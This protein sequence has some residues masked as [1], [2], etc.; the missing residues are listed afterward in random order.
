MMNLSDIAV[1]DNCDGD[2]AD[3]SASDWA[4]KYA[5]TALDNGMVAGNTNFRPDDLVSMIEGLK[6]IFQA[7]EIEREDNADWRAGY[8]NT[9]VEMG[10]ATPFTN[11][12]DAVTRGQMFIWAV[13]AIDAGEDVTVEDDLLCGILGTCDDDMDDNMDNG[14]DNGDNTP[15]TPVVGGALEFSLSPMTPSAATIPGGVNGLR[16]AAYDV[17]AG[18]SDVTINQVTL[19][20]RGLSDKDTIDAVALFGENGRISNSRTFNQ[21]ND[22]EAQI[23]LDNGGLVVMAGT[24]RT[25]YVV[26]DV[27][28]AEAVNGTEGD[29]FAIELVDVASNSSSVNLSGNPTGNLMRVGSVDAPSLVF[30]PSGSVSNPNLGELNADIFEF[31]IE[32]DNDEDVVL[33]SITFEANGDAEDDLM[34]FELRMGNT[35]VATTDMMS[36]DYLTF[37][38]DGGLEIEEDD[39]EDFTVRADVVSWAG[40]QIEFKIDEAL[41]V[42]ADSTT[43]G[44]GASAN[45][46]AVDAFGDLGTITIEAGELTFIEVEA[47]NDEIREDKENVV[48]GGFQ[49]INAANEQLEIEEFAVNIEV[50]VGNVATDYVDSDGDMVQ[51]AGETAAP[52]LVF[53]EVELYNVET[54][55]TYDLDADS[56]TA[57]PDTDFRDSID[58]IIPNGTSNWEIRA[59]T[60]EDIENFDNFSIDLEINLDSGSS[61]VVIRETDDDERVTDITPSLLSFNSIDGSE[62]GADVSLNP[63]ADIQVVRGSQDIETL[64][65]EIEAEESSE[66]TVEEITVRIATDAAAITDGTSGTAVTRQQIT[67]VS[68][69]DEN[70]NVLDTVSGSDIGSNGDVTF[71]DMDEFMIAAN[72]SADFMVYVDFADADDAVITDLYTVALTD[73]DLE[74]DDRDEIDVSAQLPLA[75]ARQITVNEA[76]QIVTLALDDANEDN[77]F[78]KLA[79]AGDSKVIASY[80]VRADNEAVDVEEVIFTLDTTTSM[81]PRD[82][83]ESAT[84]L[85]DGVAV[86]T[87]SN[88][89]IS[90]GTAG[91]GTTFTITFEDLDAL[92]IPE[93][94]TEMALQLNL[95]NIGDDF[96][97]QVTL[98]AVVTDVELR[99]AEGVD[100][101]KDL[102]NSA[103]DIVDYV[104]GDSKTLDVVDAIVTPAV[105]STFGTDDQT[106]ELRLVV[107]AGDNTD[108]TG[109]AVQADLSGLVIEISSLSGTGTVTVFNGNGDNVGTS[110]VTANGA[111]PIL[112]ATDSIG[113][114]NEIY[115]IE[116]TAE[117]IYRL[118]KNGIIYS[119]DGGSLQTKLENTLELG[120]YADSN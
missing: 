93:Q 9:A 86:E 87:G 15:T 18:S 36:G 12:D 108:A 24:T 16:V 105:V 46:N 19:A 109:D 34:N 1:V 80:D 47:P 118:A 75:S 56:D 70:G 71:D 100:S 20:R 60:A 94:T 111:L 41:D 58:S 21:E 28:S 65:F 79:L 13:E 73:L 106:A 48:L 32:G 78:D 4:C 101:G 33:Q 2:F 8:V 35:V 77:E 69:V 120:Q 83:I 44:F 37:V 14:D 112:I 117:A 102:A 26:V 7:R 62:S 85:L 107:D 25:I 84:L 54:G 92:I 40:D 51:D 43:F 72:G 53:E 45:I 95:A 113:N 91:A 23:N 59:D 68:L 76:G 31:E 66:I 114:D 38:I 98:G 88:S 89:D 57:T 63:L 10:I 67:A 3:L 99:D 5:E 110:N 103:P 50:T 74:D 42:T 115:R 96:T 104:D 116:T 55:T 27:N 17:T 29:E 64:S 82:V 49:I 97:G 39:N 22:T 90:A 61:D 6:M 52:A 11:Y 119:T 81:I 30:T